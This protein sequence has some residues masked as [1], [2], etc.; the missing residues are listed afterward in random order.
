MYHRLQI[1]GCPVLPLGVEMQEGLSSVFLLPP[2]LSASSEANVRVLSLHRL[3][4][5]A[6][7][8]FLGTRPGVG[9]GES[10]FLVQPVLGRSSVPGSL[11]KLFSEFPLLLPIAT[12]VCLVSKAGLG[13]SFLPYSWW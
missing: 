3:Q 2:P 7:P 8:L 1:V 10:V 11:R 6:V 12:T 9:A 5:A 13:G 4:T